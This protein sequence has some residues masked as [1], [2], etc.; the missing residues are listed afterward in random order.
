MSSEGN[1]KKE[2][3]QILECPWPYSVDFRLSVEAIK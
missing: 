2:T 1:V 3:R